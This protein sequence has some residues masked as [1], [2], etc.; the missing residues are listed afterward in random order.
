[1]GIFAVIGYQSDK[2]RPLKDA[3]V[4]VAPK[5]NYPIPGAPAWLVRFDGT[6]KELSDKLGVTDGATSNA[7]IVRVEDY[8]GRAPRDIWEWIAVKQGASGG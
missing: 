7:V 6:A 2:G 5:A 8:F 3:V 4:D 1:M